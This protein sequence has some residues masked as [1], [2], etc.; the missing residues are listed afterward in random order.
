M[1]TAD[2][3]KLMP[4]IITS[5]GAILI[6]LLLALKPSHKVVQVSCLAV[7][8]F[9]LI[10]VL[11][12]S[13]AFTYH[14]FVIDGF[15]KLFMGLV[16]ASGMTITLISYTYFNEKEENPKVFYVLLLLGT[17]GAQTLCI[18][19]HFIS[20]FLG[21]EILSMA[22]YALI[23]YLRNRSYAVEAGMKY[24]IM[25]AFSSAFLLFGMA[26]I[27]AETGS[28]NFEQI[29]QITRSQQ[30]VSPYLITGFGLLM[31]GAGFK[32]SVVP[33]H[34]WAADVY[35]G[36]SIPVTAFIAI[37]SKGGMLIILFRL[38][39]LTQLVTILP[40]STLLLIIAI[41]SMLVGN[42]LA[43]LQNNLKRILAYSSI[44]N[45]GYLIAALLSIG[46]DGLQTATLYTSI[47]FIA[48]LAMF[49]V[50][51]ILSTKERDADS[52]NDVKGLFWHK[53]MLATI[54]TVAML[55][56][57]GIPLTAGFIGKFYILKA[58]VDTHQWLLMLTLILAS[59]FGLFYYLKIIVAL[60]TEYPQTVGETEQLHPVSYVLNGV[61]L[62]ILTFSL[63][64][65]GIF[66]TQIILYIQTIL[67]Y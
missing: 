31:V 23:A 13:E 54:I 45:M 1:P 11:S 18:S 60:F 22:L 66:P 44:A 63:I 64:Y 6:M 32:L 46:A 51:S 7:Y 3:V 40:I 62:L 67:Q 9:D 33:F 28:M 25:A 12:S 41:A 20:L 27:Y 43:L 65:F 16:L 37:V 50:L 24:L 21:L 36:A 42:L 35:Q 39:G 56:L 55:S 14:L 52:L 53:P 19:H 30:L 57:A 49:G 61:A 15:G 59:V 10:Y 38:L 47:Y 48:L 58:G 8:L 4:L 29:A 5:S 17:L 26:L 2:L 34:L